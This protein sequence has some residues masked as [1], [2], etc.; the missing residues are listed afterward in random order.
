VLR[1]LA[2]HMVTTPDPQLGQYQLTGARAGSFVFKRF[3]SSW[4]E[5]AGVSSIQQLLS[6]SAA[7]G[8]FVVEP[9]G[10]ELAVRLNTEVLL[11]GGSSSS[12]SSSSSSLV[13][14]SAAAEM[15]LSHAASGPNAA[16][17]VTA[18]AAA[19]PAPA[20]APESTAADGARGDPPKPS[21]HGGS[22]SS[23]GS[24]GSKKKPW[25]WQQPAWQAQLL[26]QHPDGCEEAPMVLIDMAQPAAAWELLLDRCLHHMSC[27]SVVGMACQYVT[28]LLSSGGASSRRSSSHSPDKLQLEMVQVFAPATNTSEQAAGSGS[29]SSRGSSSGGGS[30][31]FAGCIY[32]LALP[33]DQEVTQPVMQQLLGPLLTSQQLVKVMHDP[34][35]DAAVL[36]Q[37]YGVELQGVLDT[38]LLAGVVAAAD[39]TSAGG[40]AAQ[41]SHALAAADAGSKCLQLIAQAVS[42]HR[43]ITIDALYQQYGFDNPHKRAVHAMFDQDDRLWYR[44]PLTTQLLACAADDVRYLLP[45]AAAL[46]QQLPA[47]ALGFSNAVLA[48]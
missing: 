23:S 18:A 1:E 21:S 42:S 26:Q 39:G 17:G 30:G 9:H 35:Q 19:V 11:A 41:G 2:T 20:G 24:S 29:S 47:A 37:Q 40:R 7:G 3:G 22:G 36:Q 44:R 14:S 12:S 5:V 34:R 43:D 33:D 16:P 45:V 48:G 6:S 31:S 25:V 13:S 8:C 28:S 27:C 15:P 4:K 32:L 10:S 46:L 38:A